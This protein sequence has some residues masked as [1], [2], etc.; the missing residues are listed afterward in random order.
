MSVIYQINLQ[1]TFGGGEVYTR[2]FTQAL[3][4]NGHQ[5]VLFVA[6]QASFWRDLGLSQVELHAVDKENDILAFLPQARGVIFTHTACGTQFAKIVSTQHVLAG[7]MHM[8]LYERL[9][10]SYRFYARLFGV[11]NHVITSARSRGLTNVDDTPM[12]AVADLTPR[13]SSGALGVQTASVYDWDQ[14]KLRDRL[15]SYVYPLWMSVRKKYTFQRPAGLTLAI[16]SRIT[17]IK[18]FPLLFSLL[19]PIL[20]KYPQVQIEFFGAGGYAS[21]RDLRKALWP[22]R[23]QVRFWGQQQN[24]AGIYANVDAV[25][26]G[27]PEKEA[28]GLNLLEAQAFGTPVIAVDAAPF[29]ETINDGVTGY[30]YTD[31]RQDNG[32]GFERLLQRLLSEQ[33]SHLQK[34]GAEA[35]LARFSKATFEQR[36]NTAVL[37]LTAL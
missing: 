5:V 3:Q 21:I 27:L 9:P 4:A 16:V 22:I 33:A 10:D 14:R 24:V 34:E 1:R 12:Y 2:F 17:P 23:Q 13:R 15:L 25:L 36:V 32:V 29:T 20:K 18:Q 8:P 6:K 35:H 11:S 31:P 26:S 30:L 7:L 37:T 19:V 28:L